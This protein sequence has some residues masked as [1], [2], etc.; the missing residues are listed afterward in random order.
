VTTVTG[1]DLTYGDPA[2]TTGAGIFA[3]ADVIRLMRK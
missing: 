3:Y 2:L 1:V